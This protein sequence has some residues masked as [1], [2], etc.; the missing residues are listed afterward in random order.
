MKCLKVMAKYKVVTEI[1]DEVHNEKVVTDEEAKLKLIKMEALEV[2]RV[3]VEG[4]QRK[5]LKPAERQS[6]EG[7]C[8]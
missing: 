3:Y 1:R 7:R 4:L 8:T 2:R 6:M 5:L